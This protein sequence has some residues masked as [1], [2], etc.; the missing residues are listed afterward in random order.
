MGRS[1]VN[2]GLFDPWENE[3]NR[4][5]WETRKKQER[6]SGQRDWGCGRK[7]VLRN[8]RGVEGSTWA[9]LGGLRNLAEG[10]TAPRGSKE[11]VS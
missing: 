6:G 7:L 2:K 3:M 8:S 4:G 9:A 1:T 11:T 5:L 10:C